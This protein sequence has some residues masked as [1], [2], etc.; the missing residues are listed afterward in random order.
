MPAGE[1]DML[2]Y[3]EYEHDGLC[4]ILMSTS[5]LNHLRAKLIG[6]SEMKSEI[7]RY[8]SKVDDGKVSVQPYNSTDRLKKSMESY[9]NAAIGEVAIRQKKDQ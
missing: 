9:L 7:K 1:R 2:E 5:E 6:A 4:V 3:V 8:L